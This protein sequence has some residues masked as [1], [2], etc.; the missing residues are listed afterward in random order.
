[1]PGP[2]IAVGAI[3]TECN[4]LGGLPLTLEDFQ[5]CELFRGQDMLRIDA[6][7]V[8]GALK[9]L[10][11]GGAEPVP[12]LWASA[13]P[14]Q[15]MTAACYN[16][17]KG[18]M[19]DRLRKIMPVDG[20][21]MPLHGS[22]AAAN[23]PD[24]EGDLLAAVR[25]IV[26]DTVPIVAT[27]DLHADVTEAMVRNAD[28]LVVWETY[29]HTDMFATSERGARLLFD[30]LEGRCRPTM[31]MAKV[32]VI[33]SA[34]HGSTA[35]DDPLA[36][37]LRFAKSHEGRNGVLTTGVFLVHPY[38]D[39]PGM[40]SGGL[41]ITDNDMEGAVALARRIGDM[42]WSKRHDLEPRVYTPEQ[43]V[44]EG[45]K[46][47]GGPVILVETADCSGGG[48]AGDSV[49]TLKALLAVEGVTALAPVVD[50]AAA[51]LCHKT[52]V[53][54]TITTKLGHQL[55]PRWGQPITVTGEVVRVTDGRFRY[56]GGMWDATIGEMGPTAVLRVG[57]VQI[58]IKTHGTYDWMD[59]QF[60]SVG[61]DASSVKFVV[62]KNP[63]NHRQAYAGFAKTKFVLDTPGPT[64]AT[65]K[66]IKFKRLQRPYFPAD[67]D[68]PGFT[69]LI[70][71]SI[72][73][74]IGRAR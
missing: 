31:A 9:G 35:G 14:G 22:A 49:A 58:L 66:N 25:A 2:R 28:A 57:G 18:D 54:K 42:Y 29:P 24:P 16:E 8:G 65:L 50:P 20:V 69:P 59:E 39:N 17:L 74:P 43:A 64:P 60:Q 62:A 68:I 19:L 32:P 70:F 6:S 48:A 40:G 5:R 13:Y 56:I 63:M 38:L 46:V 45:M 7:A 1:M 3:F 27:V 10:R 11:D 71:K 34:I 73:R 55:D 15:P 44:A 36:Q 41:A 47:K 61:L 51:L 21:L 23:A 30:I 53:G 4:D 52:G 37:V 12:L 72:P 67:A 33:T 26:G